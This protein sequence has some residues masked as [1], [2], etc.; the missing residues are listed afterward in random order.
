[1][2]QTP[3]TPT[4]VI[5]IDAGVSD[6]KTLVAGLSPDIPVILLPAGSD[7]VAALAAGLAG[8]G[9]LSALHL[10]S[11]GG[12]GYLQL[13]DTRFDAAALATHGDEL[14][15][16]GA[17]LAPGADL[18]VYGCSVAAGEAGAA[19]VADLAAALGG[20]DIAASTD[21]TGPLA[22]G[23]DW[24]LEY[25]AGEIETVLPFTVQG[26]Q[27][28]D[29]CLGCTSVGL[30]TSTNNNCGGD[31]TPPSVSSINRSG[32]SLTNASSVSFTVTFSENVSGVDSSDFQLTTTDT[33]SGSIASVSGSGSS[34][35]V[36]VNSV[37]GDGMLRLDLKNA[38]TGIADT[39]GNAIT[40]GFT[41]GQTYTIDNTA[42][43][44]T[45]VGVPANATYD[46]GQNLDFTV[47]FDGAV[48]VNTGG[49]TPY[50]PVTLD[51]GGIVQAAYLSGSGA[52]ALVFRYTVVG[53]NLD[54]N[55]I[56][57]GVAINAN[58]GTLRDA[59]G[60][61][62][63]LTLNSVG[64]TAGVLV[65]T[66]AAPA[67]SALNGG[68]S[69]IEGSSAVVVDSDVTVADT[70]LDALASGAGNYNGASLTIARS[71]GANS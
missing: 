2:S 15:A 52:S 32:S 19:F 47:N 49:G 35:T 28:I 1:M 44:V 51:T 50:I 25:A 58:D 57:V 20:A 10:V 23:G 43:R 61:D 16:I 26:M 63:T 64:A 22:L 37:S 42:P 17:H 12:S 62:A 71:G 6:W 21:R 24:D 7:G 30:P 5:V 33:A 70:E 56:A 41:L 69:F 40:T 48:T 46:I 13:G 29:Q 3:I 34:Y 27:G 60:N 9:E 45:S 36:T 18:L 38:G 4:E 11:H 54:S 65:S 8:Y 53:G 14:A 66:N 55:G 68:A 67:F 59:A 31:T 39:P